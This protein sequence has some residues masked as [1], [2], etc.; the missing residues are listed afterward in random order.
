[1]A[2]ERDTQRLRELHEYYIWQVNAAV[3][4]GRDDLVAELAD[5]YLED[6]LAELTAAPSGAGPGP[7]PASAVGTTEELAVGPTEELVVG[8]TEQ[9][10][11]GR[12]EELAVGRTATRLP[13]WR[14]VR[15]W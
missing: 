1:M 2:A 6:A 13:W 9:L 12:T 5:Q 8:R 7:G 3:G 4:E 14:R 15:R 11:G 10:A